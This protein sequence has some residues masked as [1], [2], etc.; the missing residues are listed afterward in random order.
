MGVVKIVTVCLFM[1]ACTD[2]ADEKDNVSP[3][4]RV[5]N[6]NDAI[7]VLETAC[8]AGKII[9][10]AETITEGQ[11]QGWKV[12]F[13]DLSSILFLSNEGNTI[14]S[15][16]VQNPPM[17]T[18]SLLMANDRTFIFPM[19]AVC[20][21]GITLLTDR[22][23]LGKNVVATFEFQINPLNATIDL[24]V[25]K[26]DSQLSLGLKDVHLNS[27]SVLS[28]VNYK[29]LRVEPSVDED[30]VM[31]MGRYKVYVQDLGTAEE[32]DEEA[33]VVVSAK[34]EAGNLVQFFSEP[35]S[36]CWGRGDSFLSFAI[37]DISASKINENSIA[38][39][40]PY[41]TDVAALKA[42]FTSNG[43]KVYVGDIEQISGETV[44]DF[45]S[46]VT[47]RVNSLDG[48][49]RIYVVTVCYSDLPIVYVNT[50]N[51][52]E[53][54][55][56]DDWVKNNL[57][58]IGNTGGVYDVEYEDINI[59][60][61]GNST[62]GF[63]KKPYA[64]KLDKKA[65]VLGMPKHK[66]WCLLA[67]WADR[68]L[69]RNAVA[70]EVARN[71]E[72]LE[73]TPRGKFVEVVLNGKFLGNYYLCEQIKIDKNRVNIAEMESSDIGDSSITGGYLLEL[74]TY[75]DEVNKFRSIYGFDSEGNVGMPVNIKEPDEDV[76]MPVQFEYIKN[77]FCTV[78][79]MLYAADFPT[80]K[81]YKDY[82]DINTF[83][84]WWF[85]YELTQ[86]QEPN[87]PKSSYM[88]K[89]RNGK[90]K[91][92]P[93]WDFDFAFFVPESSAF[94]I[95]DAIWYNRLF[96]D[97]DFV[98]LVRQKWTRSKARFEAVADFIDQQA[99][100]IK[101]SAVANGVQ[102]PITIQGPG[103]EYMSFDDAVA[104]L[105]STYLR[106]IKWMDEAI[107]SD[108]LYNKICE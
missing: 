29:L 10:S 95:K 72:S 5:T 38:V 34:D 25:E 59:K 80:N 96:L 103:D 62:W 78:E 55:S 1:F 99:V 58:V 82:I 48:E 27:S 61:R 2:P 9:K 104:R 17:R 20:P 23:F 40:L 106:R 100:Y 65:E 3:Q 88:Y 75:Y 108:N 56:K 101:S 14:I 50:K 7:G 92:G 87:H 63:P 11:M 16:V 37:G 71:T 69:M 31:I 45:S 24:D 43:S 67:N 57:M 41:N 93:V 98:T 81:S 42:S 105:K 53:I 30:G 39:R 97:P 70:F 47:Y 66:R 26:E 19:D 4:V 36:I 28:P 49:E 86:N 90:L 6:L 33:V 85:V 18:M 74:D 68:T 73:W 12:L 22:L 52:A 91:A 44:N 21:T 32:Y 60:G 46:P 54:T 76:L 102:W 15:S 35:I 77:Y 89:D 8:N 13:S 94:F 83:V 107:R 51:N 64:L 79:G 84:D